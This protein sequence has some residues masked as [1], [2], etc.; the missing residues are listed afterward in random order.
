MSGSGLDM[1]DQTGLRII[2]KSRSG[3]EIIHLG[4]NK[5]MTYKQDTIEHI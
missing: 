5:L 2:K 4:H 1:S 3:A